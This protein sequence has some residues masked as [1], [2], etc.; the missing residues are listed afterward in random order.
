MPEY[1]ILFT[2]KEL[3][4]MRKAAKGKIHFVFIAALFAL[5]PCP[6]GPGTTMTERRIPSLSD[7]LAASECLEDGDIPIDDST[8]EGM[9]PLYV[10]TDGDDNNSGL[11]IVSP[12]RNL[13][14]AIEVANANPG[15]PTV[16]YIRGGTYYRPAIYEYLEIQRGNLMITSYPGESVTIR[17]HFW[18]NNPT[19]WG[20][21]VFL[22][23]FG[24]Y[25]NIVISDLTLQ[26]WA[27][28]FV[29]GA[30]LDVAAIQN[31]VIKNIHANEFRKRAPDFT[32]SFFATNYIPDGYFAGRDFD[33]SDP[34]IKYQIEGLILSRIYLENVDVPIQIGD[35][36]DA[37]VK[38]LRLT[39][40][41][42]R[43]GPRQIGGTS[44][45]DGFALVNCDK[46]LVD[47]CVIEN[48]EDDGIDAKSFD[49]CVVNT[50]VRGAGRNAV[51]F[52]HGGELINSIIYDCTPIDD[53]A[54]VIK[55]G[56]C[57]MINSLLMKKSVGYAGTFD[58]A[59]ISSGEF[60]IVNSVFLDLDHT[61]Y[62][63]SNRLRSMNSLYFDMPGGIFSG[64]RAAHDVTELNALTDC[65]N[66]ICADPLFTNPPA[67]DFTTGIC[68]PCRDGG[69]SAGTLL[70]SFDY[71]GNPRPLGRGYDIGPYEYGDT[72]PLLNYINLDVSP[73]SV[74]P[75]EPVALSYSCDFARWNYSGARVDIYLVV[76]KNPKVCDS[77][78]SVP[79]A[80][81]GDMIYYLSQSMMPS[82]NIGKPTFSNISFPPAATS[83]SLIFRI[84]AAS[85]VEGEWKFATAF[86]YSEGGGSVRDD[87]LL[88]ENSR[89][90][91]VR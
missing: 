84:P 78:S 81:A 73:A 66:N 39:E 45:L 6:A 87:G 37:N 28:P 23:S 29:F 31:L 40:V 57:R 10:T 36:D 65:S 16:I 72:M 44:A 34:G 17:P 30:T 38:G 54:F 86:F 43:N 35:E 33:P 49:V 88:V 74:N 18:P 69:T 41:E 60:E 8:V 91:N 1:A 2:E 62:V 64:Q 75:G 51:K 55:G 76:V 5:V 7:I 26:G 68:S 61:F 90:F 70:P 67:E 11:S 83:G 52:W 20:G 48:I 85:G 53:G 14:A 42:V 89:R 32:T 71:M 25:H 3:Q 9:T 79:D 24:P 13:G 4:T 19:S 27:C 56:S 15:I 12:K 21:E 22:Y 47:D 50:L 77:P 82:R 58:Y 46:V 59:G 63:G 80:R